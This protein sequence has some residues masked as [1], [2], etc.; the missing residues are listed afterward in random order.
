MWRLIHTAACI[1]S[2]FYF[3]AVSYS[4]LWVYHNLC[5]HL[6]TDITNKAAM[7]IHVQVFIAH[8]FIYLGWISRSAMTSSYKRHMFNF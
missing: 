6:Y 2:R 7:N 4:V 5:I 1:S 3:N 8:A